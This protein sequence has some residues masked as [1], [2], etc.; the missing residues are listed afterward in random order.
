M[1]IIERIEDYRAAVAKYYD[2]EENLKRAE[3]EIT[4]QVREEKQIAPATRAC[5]KKYWTYLLTTDLLNNT[6]EV[7][8]SPTTKLCDWFCDEPCPE[9]NCPF[10][11]KNLQYIESQ[12]AFARA[13][14]AKRTALKAMFQRR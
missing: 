10:H 6:T 3:K 5:I 11:E 2:A 14:D 4:V 9:V 13:R 1:T 8:V 7:V 12:L